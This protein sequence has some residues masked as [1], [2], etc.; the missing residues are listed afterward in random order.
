[1]LI[2]PNYPALEKNAS[3]LFWAFVITHLLCWTILP[4][5]I[6][7]NAPLDVVE[8]F[9]WGNEMQWGYYKHPPLQAWLLQ[10]VSH[11][12]GNSGFG[13]FGLSA[14]TTSI[15]L[16]AV[17]RTGRLF[18]TKAKALIATMLCEGIL[19]FNFLSTEFNPN[20]LQLMTWACCAYAFANAMLRGKTK[21]W[22]F[23]GMCFAIGFYAKYSIALL[24]LGFGLFI[25]CQ[26]EARHSLQSYKPYLSLIIFGA[27]L[28]PHIIWLFDHHFL[29]FTY[30]ISRSEAATDMAQRLLF[31]FKFTLSQILDMTPMLAM[32][33]L[34][35]D[36][37]HPAPQQSGFRK[38]LLSLLAFAPL[39]LNFVLSL[40]TGHKA[41]DMW[42]MPYLSF[43]PLWI[44]VNMPMDYSGKKLRP[45]AI[46]W[47]CVFVL[48]L[49]A[50]Y[51]SVMYSP[52]LG[53][54]PLRG[55]FPGAALSQLI[56]NQWQVQN[57]NRNAPLTYIISDSWLGG[58]IALYAP[59]THNRPHVFIDWDVTNS[60]WIDPQD[61]KNKGA[62][63]IWHNREAKPPYLSDFKGKIETAEL[64]WQT[65]TQKPP[66]QVYWAI[67]KPLN[68]Y[69]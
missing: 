47:A 24:G 35:M 63:V 42:G 43:I 46:S 32:A 56:H 62:V 40:I 12:F 69:D 65:V 8:G 31:P 13:Y 10:F 18:T 1:M 68:D 51:V 34:L 55:H 58:N 49:S 50:F 33:W 9:V 19:Y 48:A 7:P 44:V 25:L 2:S 29:P 45:A 53:F 16:W 61:V 3:K 37:R 27:L 67:V 6:Q 26:K 11:I 5:L 57:G 59:D 28:S 4:A 39:V 20:V 64:P 14:L 60:P 38:K 36:M 17:Y 23:L 30:A 22:I 66:T 52:Q 21:H 15:S 54:K 41:L